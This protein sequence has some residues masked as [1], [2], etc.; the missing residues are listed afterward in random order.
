MTN[1][2]L[3]TNYTKKVVLQ[4]EDSKLNVTLSSK[5]TLMKKKI[6]TLSIIV[7]SSL[8]LQINAQKKVIPQTNSNTYQIPKTSLRCM[9]LEKISGTK[10]TVHLVDNGIN[11]VDE[12]IS[13]EFYPNKDVNL[14]LSE[15]N[16]LGLQNATIRNGNVITGMLALNLVPLLDNCKF[17]DI[18]KPALLGTLNFGRTQNQAK[19]AVFADH[20]SETL[21]LTGKGVK[22]GIISD[23]F[24]V[25]NGLQERVV[26]GDLPGKGNP[27]G[28][29]NDVVILRE[30]QIPTSS[31]RDEGRAMAEL[32]HDIAPEAEIYFYGAI[33]GYFILNDAITA[34]TNAGC[35]IIV[36][37][38]GY[39]VSPVYQDGLVANTVNNVVDKGVTYFSAAGNFARNSFEGEFSS[40]AVTNE[41]GEVIDELFTY[42]NGE[43]ERL[44]LIPAATSLRLSL[45][46]E[47][48]SRRS[49]P[50]GRGF[51]TTDLDI[52]LRDLFTDEILESSTE[53]NA[54]TAEPFE[55]I[56]YT[57]NSEETVIGKI[58]IKRGEFSRELPNRLAY[59]YTGGDGFQIQSINDNDGN[60]TVYGHAAAT[61]AITVG[62][63]QYT[64]S[65][66]FGETPQIEDFS[67]YGGLP[68][69]LNVASEP[70]EI[71]IPNKPDIIAPDGVNNTT[72]GSL[73][74]SDI[75]GDGFRNFFGT[76]AAAPN[77]AAIAA[78]ML[79]ANPQLTPANIKSTLIETALDMDD[80]S[81]PDI[82]AEGF[83]FA[84]GHGLIQADKAIASVI[85]NPIVYRIEMVDANTQ[86]LINI[87]EE[88]EEI[89]L[90]EVETPIDLRMLTA[91][92]ST[93]NSTLSGSRTLIVNSGSTSPYWAVNS[94]NT[95]NRPWNAQ[96]DTYN[97]RWF[98]NGNEAS[99]KSIGNT[100]FSVV[101]SN[102]D[103]NSFI[104]PLNISGSNLSIFPNPAV[105]NIPTQIN[106]TNGVIVSFKIFDQSGTQ[107]I[108]MKGN[109]L[110]ADQLTSGLYLL[111]AEDA[112]GKSHSGRITVL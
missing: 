11:I 74:S 33:D 78:L 59:F 60:G 91:N 15:L 80:P 52:E 68:K 67:S 45:L 57:N 21:G 24:N 90:S 70:M 4:Y 38:I 5:T 104:G 55:Q 10:N 46:W 66:E 93:I 110:N 76:S 62:A 34:L 20:I 30:S 18:A 106:I 95:F 43:T 82:F 56:T 102:F 27:N 99:T 7:Y 71:E 83:D 14:L 17:L 58:I 8:G 3:Q 63:M 85:D 108:S 44:V 88:G 101:N 25:F 73:G 50:S 47:D 53:L 31:A 41:I 54:I 109:T 61:G 84:S 37:D 16:N 86:E 75:E 28:F 81:D 92:I 72:F 94:D 35:D 29:E 98:A 87:I 96:S 22:I 64:L 103:T 51:L 12:K 65:P 77:A 100:N 39:A 42:N 6:I 48:R 36:D 89:D 79:Q 1:N 23:T 32:I 107:L 111:I 26:N 69:T 19:S 97:L 49:A 40:T 105:G 2:T 9:G 13:I 112:N